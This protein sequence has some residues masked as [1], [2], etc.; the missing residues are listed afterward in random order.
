VE[1]W[2]WE[3][4]FYGHYRYI[5]NHCDIIGQ[6]IYRIRW[7]TSPLYVLQKPTFDQKVQCAQNR[8]SV[9]T[10]VYQILWKKRKIRAIT[11][12]KVIQGHLGRTNRKPVCDFL[13][14]ISS[15]WHPISYRFRVIAAYCS[16]FG[17]CV[18]EPRLSSVSS[19]CTRLTDGQTDGQLSY[20]Y[21]VSAFNAAR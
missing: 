2:N 18:F 5:F 1:N 11:T 14:V 13:L 17:P 7:K 15:N 20:R 6:K 12:F 10:Q 8:L 4:I 19:Q 9:G 3:T 21:T 16:N